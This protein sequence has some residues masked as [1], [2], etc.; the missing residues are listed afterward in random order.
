MPPEFLF[1]LAPN[2]GQATAFVPA[3]HV[4]ILLGLVARALL[5]NK[6]IAHQVLNGGGG[7]GAHDRLYKEFLGC[8]TGWY[9]LTRC[10]PNSTRQDCDGD[11]LW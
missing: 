2:P 10:P 5:D 3:L 8:L 6:V 9:Y 7:R 4:V 1:A 11:T